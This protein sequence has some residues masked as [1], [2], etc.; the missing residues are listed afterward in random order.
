MT[1]AGTANFRFP[2]PFERGEE[3][4]ATPVSGSAAADQAAGAISAPNDPLSNTESRFARR[5]LHAGLN[6]RQAEVEI[7]PVAR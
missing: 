1:T 4:P 2:L 3:R 5:D 6:F 7:F